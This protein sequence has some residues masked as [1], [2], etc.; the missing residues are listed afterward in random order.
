MKN[1]SMTNRKNGLRKHHISMSVLTIIAT[2]L[3]M[4]PF[5][6]YPQSPDMPSTA[7][8]SAV[9][10]ADSCLSVQN[11]ELAENCLIEALR[12][13]PANPANMLLFSNLGVV[14]RAM[15]NIDGALIA[16]DAGLARS[17][18]STI[19]LTN[20]ATTLLMAQRF[21]D[22][23]IDL[24]K[25]LDVDSTLVN[26]RKL[27][28][29]V[30]ASK[31]NYSQSKKDFEYILSRDENDSEA[32]AGLGECYLRS[33]N[34]TEALPL[35]E[36]SWQLAKDPQCAISRT[37][38]LLRLER[39]DDARR[40]T[41]EAIHEFPDSASL[42]VILAYTNKLLHLNDQTEAALDVARRLNVDQAFLLQFF[43][44][45]RKKK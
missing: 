8:L 25:A 32:L 9:E 30:Y 5:K 23:L 45:E 18:R 29:S 10:R 7:Y 20:R 43:P 26:I 39:P 22:A 35:L 1:N 31:G 41:L 14:R 42:F 16:F 2:L 19:L 3:Y 38:A 36:K 28:A 37:L 33:D 40:A 17:P 13:E 6:M 11:W 34:A 4:V 21:D 15:G 27:R 44:N 24:N 12:I